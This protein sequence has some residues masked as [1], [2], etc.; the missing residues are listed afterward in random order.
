MDLGWQVIYGTCPSKS[1]CN[2]VAVMNGKPMMYKSSTLRKFEDDF[3]MQCGKYRG[4]KIAS[5][6]EFYCKVYYPSNS[7]DIDNS[8]KVQ[9]DCLQYANAIKNDN[10][11][12][13]VVA[14]KFI[15]KK[16]PR[17]EFKIVTIDD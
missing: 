12:I 7:H 2:R 1:N 11:C 6:F 15:D 5:R 16:V 9:L 13:K 3:L 14:E 17:I 8:L 10:L 4:M